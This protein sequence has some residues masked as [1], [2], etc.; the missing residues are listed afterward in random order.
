MSDENKNVKRIQFTTIA[1]AVAGLS[2]KMFGIESTTRKLITQFTA[3]T[4]SIFTPDGGDASFNSMQVTGLPLAGNVEADDDG[5]LFISPAIDTDAFKMLWKGFV[6][7]NTITTGIDDATRTYTILTNDASTV[8]FRCYGIEF[9]FGNGDPKLSITLPAEKRPYFLYFDAVGQLSYETLKNSDSVLQNNTLAPYLNLATDDD[10]NYYQNIIINRHEDLR[11]NEIENFASSKTKRITGGDNT[12]LFSGTQGGSTVSYSSGEYFTHIDHQFFIDAFPTPVFPIFFLRGVDADDARYIDRNIKVDSTP[13]LSD[14]SSLFYN[15]NTAGLFSKAA[16]GNNKYVQCHFGAGD[17][18]GKRIVVITGQAEYGNLSSAQSA[19][20]SE[21]AGLTV[22][23]EI[24]KITGIVAT[25][26]FKSSGN[27]GQLQ[28]VDGDNNLFNYPVGDVVSSGSPSV[29]LQN[30]QTT[31][32]QSPA[33]DAGGVTITNAGD[34]VDDQDLTTKGQIAT[35]IDQVNIYSE[36]SVNP[37]HPFK[38]WDDSGDIVTYTH[39][40]K[41]LAILNAAVE[42]LAANELTVGI[43]QHNLGVSYFGDDS[44]DYDSKVTITAD[45]G[46]ATYDFTTNVPSDT[47]G[48][49]TVSEELSI[50]YPSD[51]VHEFTSG[52]DTYY[53]YS[54]DVSTVKYWFIGTVIETGTLAFTSVNTNF[55]TSVGESVPEEGAYIGVNV[56]DVGKTGTV[57]LNSGTSLGL[58]VDTV[59]IRADKEVLKAIA[60]GKGGVTVEMLLE[61]GSING[62]GHIV[63]NGGQQIKIAQDAVED[64]EAMRFLQAKNLIAALTIGV[65]LQQGGSDALGESINNLGG[66]EVTGNQF[67]L[68]RT[69]QDHKLYLFVSGFAGNVIMGAKDSGGSV[70]TYL[71]ITEEGERLEYNDGSTDRPLAYLEDLDSKK[72]SITT[73]P[74]ADNLFSPTDLS[75]NLILIHEAMGVA[76]E[77][78]DNIGTSFPNLRASIVDN[79]GGGTA[80][81]VTIKFTKSDIN[82]EASSLFTFLLNVE[83]DGTNIYDYHFDT[84]HISPLVNTLIGRSYEASRP[85][86]WTELGASGV[87]YGKRAGFVCWRGSFTG[88]GTAGTMPVGYRPSNDINHTFVETSLVTINATTGV[89]TVAGTGTSYVDGFSFPAEQ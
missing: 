56:D 42:I 31:V 44:V 80:D 20:D 41:L 79:L 57:I 36:N 59:A 27:V 1:E 84:T 89:V 43:K 77:L 38:I 25:C 22:N 81:F 5:S 30:L 8:D 70:L 63:L 47:E 62:S 73:I 65:L 32:A 78:N 53:L 3:G 58:S 48:E 76:D 64:E 11:A 74:V 37:D 86:T 33:G 14:E 61:Y 82:I 68:T 55:R 13:Y 35:D 46:S 66:L 6:R 2:A 71:R 29:Q 49:Y 4:A 19:I 24:F 40:T 21:R 34:A 87:Y 10:I 15:L 83:F 67:E 69:G 28:Y 45:S 60:D 85:M 50:D 88:I 54:G 52:L 75:A 7:P 23:K 26:I 17:A 51:P 9:S 72:T 18:D 39:A 16:L 12:V